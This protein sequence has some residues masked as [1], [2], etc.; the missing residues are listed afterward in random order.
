M[1][2]IVVEE[3][4]EKAEETEIKVPKSYLLELEE[5]AKL[6]DEYLDHLQRLQAEYENYRKRVIKEKEEYRKY[7]LEGF[8]FE[9]LGVLDNIQRA[10]DVSQAG[11]NYESLLEGIH[12]VEKQFL[13]LLKSQGVI[14]LKTEIGEKFNPHM[15]HAVNREIV[16]EYPADTIVRI[17]QHGYKIGDRVLRP[18]SVTV[19]AGSPPHQIT[20]GEE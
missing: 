5:K 6:V 4:K 3:T 9:I 18:V 13:E 11:H 14:Q 12:I 20:G 1:E 10:I 17:L 15:H 8:L 16:K 2:T 19:S 7:I